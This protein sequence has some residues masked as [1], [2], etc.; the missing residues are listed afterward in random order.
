MIWV[1]WALNGVGAPM[2]V[3]GVVL[4]ALAFASHESEAGR[5]LFSAA[6]VALG[7]SLMVL[8]HQIKRRERLGAG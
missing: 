5:I 4:L 2:S 8:A 6:L 1:Y 3:A 7:V